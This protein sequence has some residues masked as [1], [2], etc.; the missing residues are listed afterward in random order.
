MAITRLS[1]S[2]FKSFNHLE[3][4][5]G[6]LNV[7]VGPNASGK[8]NFTQV[9]RFLRDMT[10]EGLDD[11]IALQGGTDFF[12][13]AQIGRAEPFTLSVECETEKV[14]S[15]DADSGAKQPYRLQYNLKIDFVSQRN[16]FVV[17]K[18][19]LNGTDGQESDNIFERRG[20]QVHVYRHLM[21]PDLHD[22]APYSVALRTN[23]TFLEHFTAALFLGSFI[24][25]LRCS[26]F[27]FVPNLSKRAI[28]IEGKRELEED[29]SNFAIV[30]RY[31]LQDEEKRNNFRYLLQDLLP[32]VKDI[33]VQHV[34]DRWLLF[35]LEEKYKK[36][37]YLPASLLSDGTIQ[38]ASLIIALFF[39]EKPV[40]II[41]ETDRNLY[42]AVLSRVMEMIEDASKM[43]QI[44]IT[45]HNPEVLKYVDLNDLLLIYRDKEGFSQVSRP[46]DSKRVQAFLEKQLGVDFLFVNN[47]L[48]K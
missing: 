22:L 34:S 36:D 17:S 3:I 10:T 39:V 18:E 28:P 44:V 20:E 43:K 16:E 14:V 24:T 30:L 45:T 23:E 26:I 15:K 48:G 11:A 46:A 13:N 9:F 32:F 38:L 8:S 1:V 19:T 31:L 33:D 42:P 37:F 4:E 41:E 29:G 47:L 35:R 21:L 12:L 27:D 5:L 25:Q 2:N 7:L 6:N 40:V